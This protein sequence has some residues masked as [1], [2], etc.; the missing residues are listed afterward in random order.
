MRQKISKV[1]MKLKAY[2]II[3]FTPSNYNVIQCTKTKS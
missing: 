2:C 1:F 3:M